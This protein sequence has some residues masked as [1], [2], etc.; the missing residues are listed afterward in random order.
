MTL[1]DELREHMRKLGQKGGQ[2]T[3]AR[4]SP[5]ARRKRSAKGGRAG[6]GSK[7]PRKPKTPLAE[8]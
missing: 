2:K 7:K 8:I 5:E 1:S 4:L 3:A 6:K